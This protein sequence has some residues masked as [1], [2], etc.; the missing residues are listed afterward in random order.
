MKC[1]KCTLPKDCEDCP[2][3]SNVELGQIMFSSNVIHYYDCDEWIIALLRD[4]DRKLKIVMWNI[5]QEEYE[6]PFD[7]TGNSFIGNNFEV[8]A[9]NWN[10][11]INQRFNFKCGVIEISWYKYLGRGTT[12]NGVYTPREIINMYKTCLN[13]IKELDGECFENC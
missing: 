2:V 9:Y 8:H 13:E 1:S 11:D 6:S 5:N 4:L 7:N 3:P 12:I 10:E